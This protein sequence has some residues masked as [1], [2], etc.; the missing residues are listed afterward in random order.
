M[1]RLLLLI[2]VSFFFAEINAQEKSNDIQKEKTFK[3]GVGVVDM[4]KILQDSTAYQALV[5]QFENLIITRTFSKAYGLAGIRI[6]WCYSSKKVASI[7]NKVKGPFN[8]QTLSQ[9]MAIIALEDMEHLN[10]VIK[11]NHE[12]KSWFESEL[13]KIKS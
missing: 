6:G 3:S 11:S 2:V 8:T 1:I 4:K 13:E 9:E 12:T 5:D 10:K 7:L